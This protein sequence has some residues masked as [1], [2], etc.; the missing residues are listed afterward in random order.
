MVQVGL[1]LCGELV[2]FPVA[3]SDSLQAFV[4]RPFDPLINVRHPHFDYVKNT[5]RP[6]GLQAKLILGFAVLGM[7]PLVILALITLNSSR[8][9]SDG[10]AGSYGAIATGIN[11]R[12]DRNLF[13]RY[14]DVQA[15]GVNT[16]VLDKSSGTRSARRPMAL[17]PWRTGI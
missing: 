2:G 11:D 13:E 6:T 14:G 10:V 17:P 1:L 4:R 7:L 5:K 3:Q 12:I 16:A 15:F 9:I 8:N